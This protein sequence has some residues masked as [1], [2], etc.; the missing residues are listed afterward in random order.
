MQCG[1]NYWNARPRP[2]SVTARIHV[3]RPLA[4]DYV[5]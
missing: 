2:V 4:I 3:N 1:W 5:D